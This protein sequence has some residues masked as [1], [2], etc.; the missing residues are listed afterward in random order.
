MGWDK[1][2]HFVESDDFFATPYTTLVHCGSQFEALPGVIF[3]GVSNACPMDIKGQERE[4]SGSSEWL[5]GVTLYISSK[6]GR[7]FTQ[8]CVRVPL[9]VRQS[10]D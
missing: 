10:N 6:E 1:D 5:S 8:A 2:I 7:N 9:E 4:V 3:L